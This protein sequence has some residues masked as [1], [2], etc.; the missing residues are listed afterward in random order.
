MRQ[1]HTHA[2][3][4]VSKDM[5]MHGHSASR[6]QGDVGEG[7]AHSKT[8]RVA[9]ELVGLWQIMSAWRGHV[10]AA[11]S[12]ARAFE[13]GPWLWLRELLG[14]W[15]RAVR[16]QKQSAAGQETL[17][18]KRVCYIKCMCVYVC[19]CVCC[20]ATEAECGWSVDSCSEECMLYAYVC[21]YVCM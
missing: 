6:D 5:P 3:V 15:R 2:D 21:S 12:V 7:H 13:R 14:V 8:L 1:Q 18:A 4:E 10:H 16:Q 9:Q 11:Q 20:E 19:A 17:A